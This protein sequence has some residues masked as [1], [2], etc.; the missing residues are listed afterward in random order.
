MGVG[1]NRHYTLRIFDLATGAAKIRWALRGEINLCKD[2]TLGPDHALY[3]SDTFASRIY[4]LRPGA[5]EG[6]LLIEDRTLDGIDGI[7]FLDGVLYVN[8]VISNNLYRIPLDGS[9]KPGAPDQIWPNPTIKGP[10][11]MRAA[12]GKRFLAH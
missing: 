11:G 8:N 4:R 9:G 6:E 12:Q 3:V 5:Q 1:N 10:D 2:F 7:A